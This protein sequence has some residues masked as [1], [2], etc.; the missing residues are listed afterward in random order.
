MLI[1]MLREGTKSEGKEETEHG[2]NGRTRRGIGNPPPLLSPSPAALFRL[3][4]TLGA[5]GTPTTDC[6][7]VAV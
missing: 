6:H 1:L 5:Y 3:S 2:R 7:F 4:A